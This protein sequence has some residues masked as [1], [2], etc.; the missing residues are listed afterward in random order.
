M[1]ETAT[2]RACPS[3]GKPTIEPK[4]RPFCAARCADLDLHRW[5]TGTYRVETDETPEDAPVAPPSPP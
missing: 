2:T 1:T 4:F 3:C 5:L